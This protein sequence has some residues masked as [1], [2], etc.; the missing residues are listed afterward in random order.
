MVTRNNIS[1][2]I[3]EFF[4]TRVETDFLKRYIQYFDTEP[5]GRFIFCV[6][7][8]IL[9]IGLVAETSLQKS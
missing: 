3:A 2:Q 4:G 6:L 1:V 8:K 5:R 7:F 9:I